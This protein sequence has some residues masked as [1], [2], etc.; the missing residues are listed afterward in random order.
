MA[1]RDDHGCVKQY[2]VLLIDDGTT[3]ADR[4]CQA[5]N[6][7][8]GAM[9][10]HRV[11]FHFCRIDSLEPA[12]RLLARQAFDVVLLDLNLPD[13]PALEILAKVRTAVE[14]VPIVVLAALD[15]D[16]LALNVIRQGA[17]DYLAK[18][19][20]DARVLRR[21]LLQAIERKR[22]EVQL[23]R[24]ARQMEQ[25]H[26]RIE[27]QAGELRARA[28]ELDR[29]NR[30]LGDF[31]YIAS[32]DLKE[33]LRGIRAYCEILLE[34]YHDK[35]DAT[36]HRRLATLVRLCGRLENLISDLLTFCRLGG[37]RPAETSIDLHQVLDEVLDA[38]HP[39]IE[40]RGAVVRVVGQLPKL[41]GD[42]TLIGMVLANLIANGMKFNDR[43]Q[44]LVEIGSLATDPPTL[45]VRDN[46][47]GIDPAHQRYEGTGAGLTIVKK[48][49]EL[50]GGQIWVESEP[51]E[52]TVFY[53]TLA[54]TT[55]ACT[56]QA[57]ATKSPPNPPHWTTHPHAKAKVWVGQA[58]HA[59]GGASVV[60]TGLPNQ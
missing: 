1:D 25:A 54:P 57:Q 20:L 34:D 14:N 29:I 59:H 46:G 13:S 50:H 48:I 35:L 18:D 49:V 10:D 8:C 42:S 24:H 40:R 51:G 60:E 3:E 37:V 44:P 53:F 21:T 36:G 39:T 2:E 58:N 4:G 33:P 45:Y 27:R 5:L 9:A 52:G 17:Q 15:D 55:N 22:A 32:H 23:L 30:E 19:P 31:A 41:T 16:A 11:Q 43:T 26:A 47:I 7:P 12:I 28:E 38:M 56:D 6:E